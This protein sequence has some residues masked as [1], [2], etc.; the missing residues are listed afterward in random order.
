MIEEDIHHDDKP[1]TPLINAQTKQQNGKAKAL[2]PSQVP[3]F[4]QSTDLDGR[5]DTMN[6][7]AAPKSPLSGKPQIGGF[8]NRLRLRDSPSPIGNATI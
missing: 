4:F 5:R 2:Y 1:A 8:Q 3:P 6:G 7:F